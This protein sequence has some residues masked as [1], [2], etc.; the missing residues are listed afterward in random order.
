ML[1]V[2]H[3]CR[4]LQP[5]HPTATHTVSARVPVCP[6]CMRLI[7]VPVGEL[8]CRAHRCTGPCAWA[9]RSEH[10]VSASRVCQTGS[11]HSHPNASTTPN[12]K[13]EGR[14]GG[15]ENGQDMERGK[16]TKSEKID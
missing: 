10:S 11:F 3:T 5:Q 1:C 16:A 6:P 7:A 9:V 13:R 15:W 2:Q 12:R 14:K 8:A 4:I